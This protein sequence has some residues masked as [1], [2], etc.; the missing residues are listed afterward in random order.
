MDKKRRLVGG[1]D[2]E[3]NGERV[4][5]EGQSIKWPIEKITN[6]VIYNNNTGST[7]FC[8]V[9]INLILFYTDVWRTL[10]HNQNVR[11]QT[12]NSV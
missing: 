6:Q 3:G 12:I 10:H 8:F 4:L 9:Q 2:R 7:L 11:A 5:T 1:K